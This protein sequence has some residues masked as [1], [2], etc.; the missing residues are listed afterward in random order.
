MAGSNLNKYIQKT[1]ILR[2]QGKEVRNRPISEF[3]E[4]LSGKAQ[5]KTFS[6]F[7]G[8]IKVSNPN[9]RENREKVYRNKSDSKSF[10]LNV[11][12]SRLQDYKSTNTST[13]YTGIND[14]KEDFK[15]IEEYE[16]REETRNI[17]ITNNR[18][19][20]STDS[21]QSR[22]N[23]YNQ[24]KASKQTTKDDEQERI[25]KAEYLEQYRARKSNREILLEKYDTN[26]DGIASLEESVKYIQE[27][28]AKN[29]EHNYN[30]R[31]ISSSHKD[32]AN[33]IAYTDLDKDG[34][35]SKKELV[36]LIN[37]LS[38]EE[39]EKMMD[40]KKDSISIDALKTS[41][42]LMSDTPINQLNDSIE[43]YTEDTKEKIFKLGS[44]L[45]KE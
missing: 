40:N 37:G 22:I 45:D 38:Y 29:L 30:F 11:T 1:E 31:T 32:L 15:K 42:D 19:A 17:R 10:E 5:E 41:I 25:R 9:Y 16:G 3:E 18:E 44:I 28:R 34:K 23:R 20:N 6:S 7:V 39:L 24:I 14:T 33:I 26:E 27:M 43:S 13:N 36:N 21:S 35:F 8:Q 4:K 12:S 2:Q